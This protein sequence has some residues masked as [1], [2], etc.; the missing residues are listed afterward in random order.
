MS[1]SAR[2]IKC[3]SFTAVDNRVI[4]DT[5]LGLRDLGLY[6]KLMS[7]PDNWK[8][9]EKG[10]TAV[11]KDGHSSIHSGVVNLEKCGY[12]KRYHLREDN[13]TV[14]ESVW[15][16]T[17]N[18]F[19]FGVDDETMKWLESHCVKPRSRKKQVRNDVEEE[20][21][22]ESEGIG[23]EQPQTA[24]RPAGDVSAGAGRDSETPKAVQRKNTRDPAGEPGIQIPSSP[25]SENRDLD[26]PYLDKPHTENG[27][28]YNNIK[29]KNINN[30]EYKDIIIT[31]APV[32]AVYR[33]YAGN[34][35]PQA[36]A[37]KAI[38][39]LVE[40]LG[41]TEDDYRDLFRKASQSALLCGKASP[42]FRAS[43]T[44]ILRNAGPIRNGQYDRKLAPPEEQPVP[45][46]DNCN[47]EKR[48]GFLTVPQRRYDRTFYDD[49]EKQLLLQ[50]MSD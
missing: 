23:E 13:G 42:E 21:G 48:S 14:G 30:Q 11:I 10:L 3:S 37:T 9:S 17:N 4:R 22:P 16:I 8:F 44:W 29:T 2:L 46:T 1:N 47:T 19:E 27:R 39:E 36:G 32:L 24:D 20:C 25:N 5:R 18:P 34:F 6:T 40:K 41:Y 7:F 31:A 15:L 12:L 50:G 33:E 49:L 28:Q 38:R 35:V 45:G 43:L 26:N